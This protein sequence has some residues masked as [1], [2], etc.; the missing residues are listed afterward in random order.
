ME[1]DVRTGW[2]D[3]DLRVSDHASICLTILS[4]PFVRVPA[5]RVRCELGRL[6]CHGQIIMIVAARDIG[7]IAG[8]MASDSPGLLL[9]SNQ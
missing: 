8:K 3:K 7:V 1:K 2:I 4:S 6:A 5:T 9:L